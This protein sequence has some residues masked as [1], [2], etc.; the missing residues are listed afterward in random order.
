MPSLVQ[1]T[2]AVELLRELQDR[3]RFNRID[4]YD[5]YPYQLKFHATGSG[6]SLIHI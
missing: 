5:P 6:L 1:D 4:D 3:K 2:R